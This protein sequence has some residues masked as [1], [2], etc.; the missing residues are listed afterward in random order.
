MKIPPRPPFLKGGLGG[1][2]SYG[3]EVGFCFRLRLGRAMVSYD[4][5]YLFL[6]KV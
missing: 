4:L 1:F 5:F 3:F 6:D 2:E